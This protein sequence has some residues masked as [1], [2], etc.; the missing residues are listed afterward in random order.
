MCMCVHSQT[1]QIDAI[2]PPCTARWNPRGRPPI[3]RV[4]VER[5]RSPGGASPVFRASPLAPTITACRVPPSSTS[6][7]R[8]WPAPRARR[9]RPRCGPPGSRRAACRG[10]G[11]STACSTASARRGRRWRSPA[12]GPTSPRAGRVPPMVAAGEAAADGLAAMVQPFAGRLFEE[13][14]AA[15]RPIVLA[16]T[17]PYDLV[18][19]LA[20]RLGLDDVVATR[21]G[22]NADGTYDGTLVGPVRLGRRQAG[23]RPGVGRRARRRTGG[24]LCVLGQLLRR[25]AARRRSGHRSSSTP[26][27]GWSAWRSCAGGRSS[28]WTCHRAW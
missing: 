28:T 24:E 3:D 18:R 21:Y 16:T 14:R 4:Q 5:P 7:G 22:V 23:G 20:E 26:T 19:P 13:H 12:R 9:S 2:H 25:P 27:R 15:G 11:P 1:Q 6:T 10:S 17:T 8:C